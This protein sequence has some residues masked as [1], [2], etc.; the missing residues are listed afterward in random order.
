MTKQKIKI[1]YKIVSVWN[2]KYYSWTAS[3]DDYE[4][5][6]YTIGKTSKPRSGCGP[7]CVLP[8]LKRAKEFVLDSDRDAILKVRFVPSKEKCIWTRL[9]STPKDELS[10]DTMLA[11]SIT[12]VKVIECKLL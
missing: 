1:G 4:C 9:S 12:P 8:T 10:D 3:P 2:G 6:K 5:V 11:D 7:L